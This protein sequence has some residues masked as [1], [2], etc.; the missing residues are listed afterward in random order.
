MNS[1]EK[2]IDAKKIRGEVKKL[3]GKVA[4]V[5]ISAYKPAL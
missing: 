5:K 4:S 2:K 3:E 1:K